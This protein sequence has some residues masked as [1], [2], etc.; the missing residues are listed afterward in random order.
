MVVDLKEEKYCP[1]SNFTQE[2]P[3]IYTIPGDPVALARPR[4]VN[5]HVWDSQKHLKLVA[6]IT[7]AQQHNNR[8]HYVGPLALDIIFYIEAAGNKTRRD[9]NGKLHIFKPDL[10]NLIKFVLDVCNGVLFHDDCTVAAITACKRWD[11]KARTEFK[12]TELE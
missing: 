4:M 6:G 1:R 12:I 3:N 11:F 2:H 7:L 10:D 5:K 9:R 8:P